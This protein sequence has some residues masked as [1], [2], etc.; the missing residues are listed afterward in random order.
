MTLSSKVLSILNGLYI[1]K[2]DSINWQESISSKHCPI[3][4]VYMWLDFVYRKSKILGESKHH[5]A[6]A[7]HDARGSGVDGS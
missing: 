7:L 3:W 5:N 2:P 6:G 1:F 4:L